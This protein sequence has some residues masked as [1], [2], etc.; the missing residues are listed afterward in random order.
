M[1]SLFRSC[2]VAIV[3][4]VLTSAADRLALADD[5]IKVGMI[6]P[7]SGPFA[8]WGRQF[9]AG[10]AVYMKQHG[11]MAGGKNIQIIRR[12][13]TGP[14]PDLV[15]RIARELVIN[16]KVNFITGLGFTPNA[17]AIAPVATESKTPIVIMNAATNVIVQKSPYIA[18]VSF[19]L[20]QLTAPLAQWAAKNGIKRVYMAVSDYG[21]GYDAEKA[22]AQAFTKGGG[23]IVGKV[24]IP[25][26]NP[27]FAPYI[28]RIKDTK[29][30]AV[31]LFLPSGE[32]PIGFI[33]TFNELGL[34]AA[35]IKVLATGGAADESVVDLLGKGALGTITSIHYFFGLDT[36]KNK[37]FLATYHALFGPKE[38]PDFFA[39]DAYDGMAAIFAVV[40]KLHGK[41]DGDAAMTVLKGLKL[42]SP[43]GP[44]EID[45]QTRDVV[46][47]VYI[48]RVENRNGTLA[49]VVIDTYKRI[50]QNGDQKA[51]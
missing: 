11:D 45:A 35:G 3:L 25:L 38:R 28:K 36:P 42:A 2:F 29:P 19:T 23:T 12:D 50:D 5:T 24:R 7:Y 32:E 30:E 4:T 40:E 31:F 37:A 48:R 46:Q 20:P 47:S 18:R 39:A 44:V 6:A 43:R 34:G 33:R 1:K 51:P 15:K 27:E 49:N 41:V 17:L 8:D 26:K 21:P 14:V 10:V 13:S 22:F 16:D 9:D